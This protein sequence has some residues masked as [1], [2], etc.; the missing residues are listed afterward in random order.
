MPP[1]P[2][3][4]QWV[5][6]PWPPELLAE[7]D[8]DSNAPL[9]PSR[10]TTHSTR[11][12]HWR[13]RFD[14]THRWAAPL[15]DR[16]QGQSCPTCSLTQATPNT[17]LEHLYPDALRYWD[18]Q[19]NPDHDPAHLRVDSPVTVFWRCRTN[20]RHRWS[21]PVAT[22]VR[23]IQQGT[24]CL[25]CEGGWTA[26][27]LKLFL[28]AILDHLPSLSPA[29]QFT[30]FQQAGILD[31][32]GPVKETA[33]AFLDGRL[34]QEQTEEWIHDEQTSLRDLLTH[35][36]TKDTLPDFRHVPDPVTPRSTL[37]HVSIRDIF[38]TARRFGSPVDDHRAAQFLLRNAVNRIWSLAFDDANAALDALADTPQ[39]N[40]YVERIRSLFLDEYRA[41]RALTVPDD[42][43]FQI[44]GVPHFPQLMQRYVATRLQTSRQ[45]ANLSGT[46][47]GKTIAALLASRH[48]QSG[49]TIITCPNGALETWTTAIATTFPR[50]HIVTKTLSPQWNASAPYRY[51][52]LNYETLQQPG[53][54]DQLVTLVH[55][56]PDIGFLGVDEVH[57]VKIRTERLLSLRNQRLMLLRQLLHTQNP[58]LAVLVSSATPIVNNLQEGRSVLELLRGHPL[59]HL[60]TAPTIAN[61]IALHQELVLWGIRWKRTY[62]IL[63]RRHMISVDCT[64]WIPRILALPTSSTCLQ[65]EQILTEARL[66][67][68]PQLLAPQTII[69]T[70]YT[71]Q[72][73]DAIT[74]TC[75]KAG[76]DVGLYTGDDKA[77]LQRFLNRDVPILISSN[78]VGT[79]LDGLQAIC[80]RLIIV[81]TPWTSVELEQLIG[82]LWRPGQPAPAIDIYFLITTGTYKGTVWS[83]CETKMTRLNSKQSLADA[84]VDGLI[85]SHHGLHPNQSSRHLHSW[86]HR[87]EDDSSRDQSINHPLPTHERPAS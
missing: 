11:Q 52:V 41:A 73:V 71:D 12:L 61:C 66:T 3:T 20:P 38:D 16:L 48:L 5:N 10:A 4:L 22:Q 55:A 9:A 36:P 65:L 78:I 33:A 45:L 15:K 13:C 67:V 53:V 51:L 47:S 43:S 87:L 35:L 86:L 46:G 68:L 69:F 82:R 44:Q 79:G 77:G 2:E 84:A 40:P 14:S 75:K 42:Y 1:T 29:E 59:P 18:L 62:P 64:P 60:E 30:L 63:Q 34:T 57:Q 39:D 7:W 21:A 54:E 74:T 24:P 8:Y 28:Q 23:H 19:A 72:I 81:T 85:P 76:W 58:S 6:T 50:A 56:N 80:H 17:S 83:W 70:L 32:R 37:P 25:I 31:A 27:T 26:E 49:T